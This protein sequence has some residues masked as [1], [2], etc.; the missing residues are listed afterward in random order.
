MCARL[1]SEG[2][3]LFE[4]CWMVEEVIDRAREDPAYK[5]WAVLRLEGGGGGSWC[6]CA[7][8]AASDEERE[9][10]CQGGREVS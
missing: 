7:V 9:D 2:G 5:L 3:K 4:G 1:V 10:I 6:G 8:T